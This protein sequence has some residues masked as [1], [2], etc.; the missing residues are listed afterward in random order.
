MV[1]GNFA[2]EYYKMNPIPV[3]TF[4]KPEKILVEKKF[5]GGKDEFNEDGTEKKQ[6]VQENGPKLE[7]EHSPISPEDPRYGY[8]PLH[9]GA[10]GV[11]QTTHQQDAKPVEMKPLIDPAAIQAPLEP[12]GALN[13]SK[14][15][16]GVH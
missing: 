11:A 1:W 5:L 15:E 14:P 6:A 10:G 7:P 2:R 8:S 13:R 4:P 12:G 3:T 16:T 9:P